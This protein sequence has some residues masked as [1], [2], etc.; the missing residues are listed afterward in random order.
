MDTAL[1]RLRGRIL[2]SD[3]LAC[4]IDREEIL[5]RHAAETLA[6]PAD[7]AARYLAEFEDLLDELPTPVDPDDVFLGR[8][9]EA[10]WPHAEKFTR[11]PRGLASEGHITLPV[12]TVLAR[13]LAGIEADVAASAAYLA[14][15][16]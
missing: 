2:D 8:M 5:R 4:F 3:N 7:G 11:T 1:D 15:A 13:G 14:L 9:N 12:E 6:L 16:S 10:R